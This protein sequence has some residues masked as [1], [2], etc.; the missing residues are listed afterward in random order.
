MLMRSNEVG[1]ALSY[2]S[3]GPWHFVTAIA[4][5]DSADQTEAEHGATVRER[6]I[7]VVV[8][9][10]SARFDDVDEPGRLPET[11]LLEFD[12]DHSWLPD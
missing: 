2:C 10:R 1:P 3:A 5:V 7:A 4:V 9:S 6:M 12:D 8:Q 11:R